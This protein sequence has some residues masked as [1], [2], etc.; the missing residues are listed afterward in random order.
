MS[1]MTEET[2]NCG[3]GAAT[4]VKAEPEETCQCGCCGP[5][6]ADDADAPAA[7]STR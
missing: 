2:C 4:A 6:Q 7:E 3:C 5:A 1:A